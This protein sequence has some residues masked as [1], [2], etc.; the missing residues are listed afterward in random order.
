MS[1]ELWF[2]NLLAYSLQV[3][4]LTA[5]GALLLRLARVRSPEGALAYWQVLLGAFL[6]LPA[7]QPWRAVPAAIAG[8]AFGAASTAGAVA[9]GAGYGAILPALGG[10]LVAGIA[11]R[12]I[13]LVTGYAR[14][15]RG[16]RR[17]SSLDASH[18]ILEP[19]RNAIGVRPEIYLSTEVAGPVTF[20]FL[21]PTVLVPARWLELETG[22]QRAILC[23]EFL[24]VRRGDWF[25]HA[26]EEIIR[27]VLWFH[28]AIWWLIAEIRLVREQVID[29]RVVQFTG[30]YRPYVEALL[31]FA[32]VGVDSRTAAAPA[33]SR[34]RHLARRISSILEEVSMTK[35][36]L[37]ASLAAVTLC[38][39]VAGVFAVRLFPLQAQDSAVHSVS[40]K[41]VVGPKVLS[42]ID[43]EYT[44]DAKG[45]Q[46]EGTV[47]VNLEVHPDG[48]AYHQRI[49]R[50]LDPGL[51]RNAMD[52]ISKWRFQPA[53]KDG[54]AI[55]VSATI[56]VNYRL[57]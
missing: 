18:A 9:A 50:S 34:R 26:A 28:P 47:V 12:L 5:L 19:L 38:L 53:T 56:E 11:G 37:L 13:W 24:H 8:T 32:D 22:R 48:R 40:E 42:K 21:R 1:L 55:A 35:F 15:A 17:A 31:A 52:A 23:H 41:G 4:V 39:A 25:F 3:G 27:A 45:A 57:K 36:R 6:C 7:L 30:A 14:L 16:R 54:K 43:P 49:A 10:I 51:D 20:G 2:A 33:F 29:R 46:I 44:K